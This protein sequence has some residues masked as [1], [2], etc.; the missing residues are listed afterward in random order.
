[1]LH[2][3]GSDS[4]PLFAEIGHALHLASPNPG[5]DRVRSRPFPG[6]EPP[7]PGG[8][9]PG[10]LPQTTP[11]RRGDRVGA[12]GFGPRRA[13]GRVLGSNRPG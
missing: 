3:D 7:S 8:G 1:V 12:T 4:G 2:I 6:T 11:D 9:Q 5:R 13:G 10:R